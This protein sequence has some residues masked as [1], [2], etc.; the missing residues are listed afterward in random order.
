MYQLTKITTSGMCGENI[1]CGHLV[2]NEKST[3]R[4]NDLLKDSSDYI[5]QIK[6][7]ST[8]SNN[9]NVLVCGQEQN[10]TSTTT[11]QHQVLKYN[12][13][14]NT[15]KYIE[16]TFSPGEYWFYNAQLE[17]GTV[18]TD[19]GECWEDNEYKMTQFNQ[20]ADGFEMKI[21]DLD[22]LIDDNKKALAEFKEND[23]FIGFGDVEKDLKDL[24]DR[25]KEDKENRDNWMRFDSNGNLVL[26]AKRKEGEHYYELKITK[27]EILFMVDDSPAARITGNEMIIERSTVLNDLRIG[28]F[29][30][31]VRGNGNLGLTW[32]RKVG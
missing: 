7:K 25:Y 8:A 24:R 27:K 5:F 9:I 28:Q 16:I 21:E 14:S 15:P 10:I 13:V 31:N 23:F 2:C 3:L 19:W 30:W 29:V 32:K 20:R 11:W 6:I 18:L 22:K 1:E 12:N 17:T 4:L 26:G